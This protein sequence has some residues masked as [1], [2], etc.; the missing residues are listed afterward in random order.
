MG[1]IGDPLIL[2][3]V[4][5]P[6]PCQD[7][8]PWQLGATKVSGAKKVGFNSLGQSYFISN[9]VKRRNVCTKK[10]YMRH[11]IL[12]TEILHFTGFDVYA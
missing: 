8:R 7:P 3:I 2:I 12:V 10:M 1:H 5:L 9:A 6:F 11:L 4:S